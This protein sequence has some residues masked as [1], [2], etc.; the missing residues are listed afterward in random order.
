MIRSI[1]NVIFGDLGPRLRLDRA[2]VKVW[3]MIII[4]ERCGGNLHR[5]GKLA[6]FWSYFSVQTSS[7]TCESSLSSVFSLNKRP[8]YLW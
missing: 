5:F 4:I 2:E 1:G 3:G 8:W 7:S 6:P